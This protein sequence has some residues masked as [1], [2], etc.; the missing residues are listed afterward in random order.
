MPDF[1]EVASDLGVRYC[2]T[3]TSPKLLKGLLHDAVLR[4]LSRVSATK[5]GLDGGRLCYDIVAQELR[6]INTVRWKK[7]PSVQ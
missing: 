5:L 7:G 1:A 3:A 6:S 4:E 2:L